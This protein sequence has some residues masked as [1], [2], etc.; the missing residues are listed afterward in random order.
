MGSLTH[1]DTYS[2]NNFGHLIII[3][4]LGYKNVLVEFVETKF[5]CVANRDNVING[6]VKD[7]G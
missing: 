1:G 3:R 6:R 5:R 2:T 7:K 4:D